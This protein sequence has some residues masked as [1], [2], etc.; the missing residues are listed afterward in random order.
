MPA[1]DL[2]TARWRKSS[3]SNET[4]ACVEIASA[5]GL[6][7][8]RDS[9][10]EAQGPILAFDRESWGDFIGKLKRGAFDLS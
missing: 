6:T 1:P 4:G 9:K 2:S 5:Q 3:R 8:V 10:Q 7:G